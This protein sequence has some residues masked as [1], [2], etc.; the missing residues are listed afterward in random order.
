[1]SGPVKQE[2][3]TARSRT[4]SPKSG[5][6]APSFTAGMVY[7]IRDIYEWIT[8]RAQESASYLEKNAGPGDV[9]V[10]HHMPHPRSVALRFAHS[11]LNRYFLHDLSHLVDR[12]RM[13]LWVHGHTHD[14]MDYEVNADT[15]VVCN[16][17]GYP[18]ERR[19]WAPLDVEV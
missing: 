16:P 7:Y 2:P 17:L 4:P 8:R 15:R 1:M 19:A 10:T 12:G 13:K 5:P 6:K 3:K 14:P 11:A 18:G 9:V